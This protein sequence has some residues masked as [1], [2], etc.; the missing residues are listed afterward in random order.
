MVAQPLSHLVAFAS[1]SPKVGSDIM[2]SRRKTNVW[3]FQGTQFRVDSAHT[4]KSRLRLSLDGW[5]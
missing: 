3:D 4:D 5:P 1:L 2:N